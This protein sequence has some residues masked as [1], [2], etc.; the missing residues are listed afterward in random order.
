[1]HYLRPRGIPTSDDLSRRTQGREGE[2]LIP[3]CRILLTVFLVTA[4][5]ALAGLS[6]PH[7]I[8]HLLGAGDADHCPVCAALHGVRAGV[9]MAPVVLVAAL[10]LV[11]APAVQH[12]RPVLTVAIAP[13][14][15]RGPP[16][17]R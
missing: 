2:A 17:V 12:H 6:G 3:R 14:P 1:M 15:P 16:V 4:I 13:L 5:L 8:E 9:A 7:L 11:G 10:L